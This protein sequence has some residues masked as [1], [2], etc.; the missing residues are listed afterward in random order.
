M[1]TMTSACLASAGK[2]IRI[3][4]MPTSAQSRCFPETYE[5]EPASS[6]TRIVPRPGV[7]DNFFTRWAIS[8]LM[9]A[10]AAVPSRISAGVIALSLNA[11]VLA[12][13]LN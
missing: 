5:C 11:R 3:E 12:T 6:P 4:L 2:S 1:A 13:F 7:R 10:A 8:D 9:E